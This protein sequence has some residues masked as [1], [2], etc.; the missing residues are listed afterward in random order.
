MEE[1]DIS[2]D[3]DLLQDPNAVARPQTT[4]ILQILEGNFPGG[5]LAESPNRLPATREPTITLPAPRLRRR[6]S[7]QSLVAA[8]GELEATDQA[9]EPDHPLP[10]ATPPPQEVARRKGSQ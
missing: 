2:V 1:I 5:E 8:F 6:G 4:K 10:P 7:E 9:G 3:G